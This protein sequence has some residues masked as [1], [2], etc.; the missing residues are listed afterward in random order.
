MTM[1]PIAVSAARNTEIPVR[2]RTANEDDA[3]ALRRVRIVEPL[4]VRRAAPDT[5]KQVFAAETP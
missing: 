5:P 4:S 3:S 2:R 1:P